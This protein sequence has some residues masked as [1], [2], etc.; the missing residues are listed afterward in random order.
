MASPTLL[1]QGS[2][3][4]LQEPKTTFYSPRY[5]Q[6]SVCVRS[7]LLPFWSRPQVVLQLGQTDFVVLSSGPAD[8]SKRSGDPKESKKL[9]QL[10]VRPLDD[11]R[12]AQ[13]YQT[14]ARAQLLELFV[15]VEHTRERLLRCLRGEEKEEAEPGKKLLDD[16]FAA[17]ER[18]QQSRDK[19]KALELY[20][21]AERGFWEAEKV[22]P[23]ERSRE[24]LRARRGDLQRTIRGLEMEMNEAARTLASNAAIPASAVA[25]PVAPQVHE[26]VAA[27]PTMDI[28]ARL[29]ELRRFAAQ[30]DAAQTPRGE[31]TD[32]A[33]RLAAL[34]NEKAGPAPAVEDLTERLRRLRGDT[35]VKVGAAIEG[36][37]ADRKSAVD[38]VIEQVTDEIAL[39]IEDDDIDEDE[40]LDESDSDSKSDNSSSSR[41]SRS[42][43]SSSSE[44]N[45]SRE[46]GKKSKKTK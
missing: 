13:M 17:L 22:V 18:A 36:D 1:F 27:P 10:T 9:L 16:A 31:R 8:A 34:K 45:K 38:R 44:S 46:A 35:D 43:S 15:D 20:K 28:N 26:A 32:L 11:V 12:R 5:T 29:E 42:S 37:N 6:E 30:Q 2:A 23:D 3:W 25:P 24:F 40:E 39:G 14:A 7:Q 33:A 21:E 41:S 19:V 4:L